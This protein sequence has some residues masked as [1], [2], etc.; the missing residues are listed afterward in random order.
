M[1]LK[2]K[3]AC[4][5]AL[6]AT[7]TTAFA[8]LKEGDRAPAFTLQASL[9][10]KAFTYSLKEH[11]AQGLVVVYFYPSA[12]TEGCDIEAHDYSANVDKFAAAGASVVGVSLDG[13]ERLNTFSADPDFCAGKLAVA[14]DA[15]GSTARAFD[16]KVVGAHAGDK[17]ARG[18][19]IGHGYTQ[20][21]TFIVRRD[22]TVA[23][24]VGGVSP[25]E[26]V[27]RALELVQKMS[28]VH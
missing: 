12:Y 2:Q 20:R 14:S 19:E 6:V 10:G 26:N 27:K 21:T 11:L 9:A 13:I 8:A 22:G 28:T 25:E 3:L 18:L 7:T 4:M 23:A 15:D 17:D 24:A 1:T 5:L 16:L